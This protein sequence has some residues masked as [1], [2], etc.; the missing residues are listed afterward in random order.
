MRFLIRVMAVFLIAA[1]GVPGEALC[2]QTDPS[3]SQ[4]V[5]VGYVLIPF[6]A[7]DRRG[8]AIK[9]LKA[10]EATLLIDGK[11]VHTDLFERSTNAP[12]SF[13]IL[14][15][16]SGSMAL[17]GKLDGAREAI[18][19]LVK[20]A[21]PGDE[22]ALWVFSSGEVREQV[23]FTKSGAAI[24]RALS[25]IKPYG[26]TAFY[27]A[28][29][30]MPDKSILGTNGSRAIIL[31]TD[32]LDNASRLTRS[33]LRVDL[34]GVDVPVYPFGLRLADAPVDDRN[35]ETVTDL[36]LLRE[37]AN[38][39]GGRVSVANDRVQLVAAVGNLLSDLRTQ[40]LVGFKPNGVGG[41]RYHR[42]TMKL[43]RRARS[44]RVRD[45][46]RGTDPPV[47]GAARS[48]ERTNKRSNS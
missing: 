1:A 8:R 17:G 9:D 4:S 12:V 32:G 29:S 23:P 5:S 19:T 35:P 43:S 11:R 14:I 33:E 2:Q 27:D 6:T 41:D 31:L 30:L 34:E 24:L 47:R 15:D 44:V 46:Y 16:G 36:E 10:A 38:M 22:F 20:S 7:L 3:Y 18:S 13:T 37:V 42:I 39:T 48:S 25:G 45:G 40:Y 28:L 26:K 21:I